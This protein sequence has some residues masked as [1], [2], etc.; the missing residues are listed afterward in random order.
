MSLTKENYHSLETNKKYMSNSLFK[1]F[2][3]QY[4]GCEARTMAILNRKWEKDDK[5]AFLLGGYVHA[6]NEGTLKE[7]ID[8][9]YLE[10][11]QRNGSL[12]AKYK[13]ADK[14][15]E[16]LRNDPLVEKAREGEKEVI[17]TGEL[18]GMPWKCM[19]DIYNPDLKVFAD[20]KTCREIH[21]TEWN[22]V[23]RQRENMIKLYGYD[24]QMAI[25][26]EIEWQNRP[27][28]IDY[29]QPH[30]IAVSKEDPP[31]KEII[32]FGTEFIEKTLTEIGLFASSVKA[33]W[34][35]RTEPLRCDR[36]DYCRATKQLTRTVFYMDL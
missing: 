8:K 12:Y 7:Y 24:W 11:H 32:H 19:I 10:L 34:S 20:L 31:D 35:G 13:I 1:S 30:I 17:M 28:A 26:A 27:L 36:C 21:R 15:I 16:T 5:D 9:H 4:D 6:W 33:V 23:T 29:F 2:L 3:P 14:M 25:Y 22:P 18:F